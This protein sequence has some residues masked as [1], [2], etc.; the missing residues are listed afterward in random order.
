M[1][2]FSNKIETARFVDHQEKTIEVLYK[3]TPESVTLSTY[4][5]EL[6][7][8]NQD[9][10]DLLE[11]LSI[12]QIQDN[13]KD[14]YDNVIKS[15]SEAIYSEANKLF[16]EWVNAAQKDL[17]KQDKERYDLFEKYKEE[18]LIILQSEIDEQVERRVS[19]GYEGIQA[20]IDKEY[21]NVQAEVDRQVKE[22]V[23]QGYEGIQA[24]IDKEY[25][26][27]QAE[28]DRQVKEGYEGIQAEVDRQVK[29]GYEGIQA[30]IDEQYAAVEVY[31]EA[32]LQI[33]QNEVD[34][35]VERRVSEGFKDI[36]EYRDSQLKILQSELD[37]Q[38]EE[39]YKQ[40][41][42]YRT[43]QLSILQSELDVEFQ[44][45]YDE[46]E[47]YKSE[48]I[49]NI[50]QNFMDK[51]KLG[52]SSTEEKI[53]PEN[54]AKYLVTN[55]EDEDTVFKTKLVIFNLPEVKNH[56][57]RKLKMKVRKA[58]S[59]PELFAAYYDIQYNHS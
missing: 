54:V 16:M 50:K 55:K 40:A 37:V 56:K 39:R 49:K 36:D 27:V 1:A 12:E 14:Y 3:Q 7:Y 15:K 48:E 4:I 8:N 20:V 46:V 35:Q 45:R 21:S 2:L 28:V 31:K 41:D 32:Q 9:F 6:N 33:L 23:Q 58:K 25:S 5:L 34:E 13:T 24:V 42:A 19:E 44:K 43:E 52:S 59:I 10:L 22:G 30:A 51:F 53:N 57:D 38:V 26:N 11:E 17:D 29:E 18:Q 47:D